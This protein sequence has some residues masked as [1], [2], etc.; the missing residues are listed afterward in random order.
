MDKNNIQLIVPMSGTGKRF[1]DAGYKEP[2]PLIEVDGKP[3]IAHVLD[4]FPGVNDVTFICN[5]DHV[6]NTNIVEI[7]NKHCPGGKIITIQGHKKGPVYSVLQIFDQIDDQKPVI[8]S[9]CDYGTVWNFDKFL[10][11]VDGFDGGIPCYTGFHPHMLGS[12]NYAFCKENNLVLQNIKEKEPFTKNK[13]QE[14]ASNG[15]YFFASGKILK[16]YFQKT[17]DENLNLNGEFYVSLVYKKLLED[18]LKTKI[19]E[20]EKMLQWG[21]PYDLEIYKKWSSCFSDLKL[22][23]EKAPEQNFTLILP[24]AGKGE[25]FSVEGY[26]KPKPM[27]VVD[28]YPMVIAAV[29]SLPNFKESYF[30]C[31]EN[32][33]LEHN[34]DREIQNYYPNSKIISL[35]KVTEGQACTCELAIKKINPQDS[36]L[37]SACDNG[38][39]Y[40]ESEFLKMIS[41]DIDVV[42]WTFRNNQTSKIKPNMYS[43]VEVDENNNVLSVSSKKFNG[44]DPLKKHAII[45]TFYY[46]RAQDFVNG[47]NENYR[48]NIRTNGE[49]FVDDII[50][51]NV[52]SG[53]KVKVFE[54]NHYICWGTPDDYRT[55]NYW[56]EHFVK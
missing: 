55:Y 41:S 35:S 3:I 46:K 42:V 2:K 45:G 1:V 39:C 56:R 47:L 44:G 7:L 14:Y 34:I 6:Q 25:R 29:K 9:Y 22:K 11:S 51:R 18:G 28:S 37:I 36:I 52:E 32:H 24:M 38:A 5:E 27:V 30:I 13:M 26:K 20:I 10:E 43:W 16:K 31:L 23:K 40:D 17:V 49:F 19:F 54:V 15:T 33:V 50:N 21:T 12:D 53:L 8:V 48:R 4:I